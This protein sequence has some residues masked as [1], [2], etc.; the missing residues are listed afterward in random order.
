MGAKESEKALIKKLK[1]QV[2]NLQKK[3]EHNREKLKIALH[4]IKKLGRSYK[5]NLSS[6]MRTMKD[7][8]AEAEASA[9][10]KVAAE[11][12]RQMIKNIEAKTK[13]L[14]VAINKLEKKK[15]AKLT[16]HICKKCKK[17]P[18]RL[19]DKRVRKSKRK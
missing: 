19:I 14:K 3:E 6:K 18:S 9:Y 12:E 17:R 1:K 8:I 4:K 5:F 7:K 15:L 10:S 16:K 11:L 13:T 2:K